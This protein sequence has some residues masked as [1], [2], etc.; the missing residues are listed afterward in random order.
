M[1]PKHYLKVFPARLFQEGQSLCTKS[2]VIQLLVLFKQSLV[3]FMLVLEKLWVSLIFSPKA[4]CFL[5]VFLEKLL[6]LFDLLSKAFLA[7]FML[8]LEKLLGLLIFSLTSILS[9]SVPFVSVEETSQLL[10]YLVN[11]VLQVLYFG[12]KFLLKNLNF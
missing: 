2:L 7:F 10:V 1:L 6:G 12:L 3:F 8:V 9:S 5:H 11:V 4:F